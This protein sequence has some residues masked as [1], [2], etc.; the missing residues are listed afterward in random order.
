MTEWSRS[1]RVVLAGVDTRASTVEKVATGRSPT[2]RLP[3]STKHAGGKQDAA[4]VGLTFQQT[5]ET[6]SRAL[7][8][9]LTEA[10]LARVMQTEA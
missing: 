2:P 7:F 8:R 1:L 4:I 6:L 10:C 9:P 5:F 3:A